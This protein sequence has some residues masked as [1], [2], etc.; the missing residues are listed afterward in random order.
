MLRRP[1]H[2]V[3]QVHELSVFRF[4]HPLYQLRLFDDVTQLVVWQHHVRRVDH[5]A[6]PS[7]CAEMRLRPAASAS[8]R[9]RT[10]GI[11]YRI[12]GREGLTSDPS[13]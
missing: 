11:C 7:F 3:R 12:V 4:S 5:D 13:G 8:S 10:A 1:R 2:S 6:G 9:S